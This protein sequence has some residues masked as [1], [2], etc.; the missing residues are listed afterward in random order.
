MK[1]T[2]TIEKDSNNLKM[3]QAGQRLSADDLIRLFV[4]LSIQITRQVF[5]KHGYSYDDAVNHIKENLE[6]YCEIDLNDD[7]LEPR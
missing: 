2:I 4:T 7:K 3:E 5:E 6:D 1:T